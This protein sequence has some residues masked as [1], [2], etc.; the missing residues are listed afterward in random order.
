MTGCT[1]RQRDT[2][3]LVV[4]DNTPIKEIV[5]GLNLIS[6]DAMLVVHE[7]G[8]WVAPGGRR[9]LGAAEARDMAIAMGVELKGAGVK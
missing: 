9:I 5:W 8:G 4:N 2:N 7:D 6:G 3:Q 1:S